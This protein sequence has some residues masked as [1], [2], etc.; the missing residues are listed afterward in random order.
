MIWKGS[1]SCFL[2]CLVLLSVIVVSPFVVSMVIF[3]LQP[4]NEYWAIFCGPSIDSRR[5]AVS[6]F[7]WSFEN[8]SMGWFV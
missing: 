3:G 7:W 6:Y 2:V 5:Y 8:I 4:T 1:F